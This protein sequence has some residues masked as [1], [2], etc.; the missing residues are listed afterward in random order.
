MS[1]DEEWNVGRAKARKMEVALAL[2]CWI[3]HAAGSRGAGGLAWGILALGHIEH[4]W[5]VGDGGAEVQVRC[6]V[7]GYLDTP[8]RVAVRCAELRSVAESV[9]EWPKFP[10][11]P[12]AA[13]T[14]S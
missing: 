4:F 12:Q 14:R 1:E 5:W 3:A 9:K 7:A 2:S 10:D 13:A 8:I 6:T 11:E